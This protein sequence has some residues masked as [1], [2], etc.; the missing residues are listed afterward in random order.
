[1]SDDLYVTRLRYASGKGVA[2][3]HGRSKP[4]TEPPTLPGA[5]LVGIDYVPEVHVYRIQ[6]YGNGWRDMWPHE[7]AWADGVLRELD[8]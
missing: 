8:S 1:M 6:T 5:K 2:K 4:L 7:I 3:L